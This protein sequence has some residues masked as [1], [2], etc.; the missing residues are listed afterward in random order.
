MNLSLREHSV[1]ISPEPNQNCFV[2]VFLNLKYFHVQGS[3][4]NKIEMYK[5]K[6]DKFD[7][8][9]P[10][11]FKCYYRPSVTIQKPTC[12]K[13]W[14]REGSLNKPSWPETITGF[15]ASTVLSQ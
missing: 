14:L 7:R 3:G 4:L 10:L 6:Y 15:L 1:P 5:R 9:C 11:P 2:K 13:S 12:N 8:I